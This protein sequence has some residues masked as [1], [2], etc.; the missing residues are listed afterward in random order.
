[1]VINSRVITSSKMTDG[2]VYWPPVK[3]DIVVLAYQL[4]KLDIAIVMMMGINQ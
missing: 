3:P 4:E 1:M 2:S